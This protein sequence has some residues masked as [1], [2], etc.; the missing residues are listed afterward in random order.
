MRV[1]SWCCA[2]ACVFS[3]Y[4]ESTVVKHRIASK[5]IE[6]TALLPEKAF[7]YNAGF[8][9]APD[10]EIV[11]D[12]GTNSAVRG[13]G[14]VLQLDQHEPS[15]IRFTGESKSE[16]EWSSE[17]S[18][19]YSLY[20]DITYQDGTHQWGVSTAFDPSQKTWHSREIL[21]QPSK[22]IRQLSAYALFR[23]RPGRASF[24]NLRFGSA[25]MKN[26]Q[27]FDG[28]PVSEVRS[29]ERGFIL[30][31]VSGNG[32]FVTVP[33]DAAEAKTKGI[34]QVVCTQTKGAGDCEFFDVSI[35]SPD[36]RDHAFT[37][38]YVIPMPAGA[39][40]LDA[41]ESKRDGSGQSWEVADVTAWSVPGNGRLSR[42]PFAVMQENG[43]GFGLGIDPDFPAVYRVAY[44]GGS[45]EFFLAYDLG[46][47]RECPT[48]KIRFCT[49]RFSLEE[50]FRNALDAYYRLFPQAFVRRVE[51]QGLWMPFANISKVKGWEDF[52]FRFKEGI[53]ETSWDD[54]HDILTFRYTEPMTWWMSIPKGSPYTL[55]NALEIAEGLA[56][57][58]N[59]HARA[60]KTSSFRNQR[61]E[62][63]GLFQYTPWCNGIVW[64]LNDAPGLEGEVTGFSCKARD[65]VCK[66][67][68]DPQTKKGADGEY[69]DSASG[70]VT[71]MLD[72]RRDHFARMKTPLTFDPKTHAVGIYK[73]MICYEYIKGLA[74]EAHQQ[75]RLMMA[76]TVPSNWSWLPPLLDVMGTETDWHRAK[77]WDPTSIPD[78]FYCRAL[79]R[80][81]PYCY[82]MNTDFTK[83]GYEESER[84]M[85]RSLAFGFF[86]GY[87]SADASTDQYFQN[88]EWYERD[89]PLFKK[90]IPLVRRVAEAGWEPLTGV[91][92]SEGKL[93]LER[94]GTQPGNSYLTVF[95]PTK[96][97]QRDILRFR[98]QDTSCR[99]KEL[100]TGQEQEWTKDGLAV[101]IAPDDIRLF[102]LQ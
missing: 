6:T 15:A 16:Q 65:R 29:V 82:L 57:K 63:P 86:P 42:Y 45:R 9:V 60:L 33:A 100:L 24:R 38:Y 87:F 4:A 34:P 80:Q 68:Y 11:C 48:V 90:Y 20:I 51:R 2:L 97:P 72:F 54:A 30:R 78:M 85:K 47:T 67:P 56:A 36:E 1:L 102:L 32:D 101:E 98:K 59:L 83:W 70:Y 64:S 23:N 62:V 76:N 52:G 18:M 50:G 74:D 27:N 40:W 95:N 46:L 88:P 84:F 69:I 5:E 22:P 41:G 37:L 25:Q 43:R 58:G 61:G 12:N 13:A 77:R 71:D 10:G 7:R 92:T 79:C 31:D 53:T 55:S 94:F 21:F 8:T 19:N 14:W 66:T 81:K 99:V 91:T 3:A 17:S 35:T 39:V 49:F 28:V 93:H 44:N 89:R 73:G 26:A 75:E 96:T